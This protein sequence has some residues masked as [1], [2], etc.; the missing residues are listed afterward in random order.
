M[1]LRQTTCIPISDGFPI[2]IEVWFGR[3]RCVEKV[4]PVTI[5]I[6]LSPCRIRVP[7]NWGLQVAWKTPFAQNSSLNVQRNFLLFKPRT[8]LLLSDLADMHLH[9]AESL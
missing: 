1:W 6:L 3:S 4:A 9:L 7:L 8:S 5:L 2:R